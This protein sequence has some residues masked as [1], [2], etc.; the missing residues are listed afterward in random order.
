[1]FVLRSPSLVEF[2]VV[3]VSPE[4]RGVGRFRV[5][6]REGVNRVRLRGRVGRHPL[7]PGTY[8][9]VAR[10]F[11]GGRTV[12]DTRLV[13]VEK[14]SRREL[15][16]ARGAN[17][18]PPGASPGSASAPTASLGTPKTGRPDKEAA[19]SSPEHDSG[20]LGARS[21]RRALSGV[22]HVADLPLWLFA[23]VLL[24]V[25]LLTAGVSL[26]KTPGGRAASLIVGTTGA[27]VLLVASIA[28]AVL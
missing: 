5:R 11:P 20:V 7:V 24:A 3:Q 18:C 14:A 22:T 15:R 27:V 10:T 28:Y 17:A 6:G 8:R 16:R 12:A 23:L 2:V 19:K 21:A 26:A 9:I 4:C 25:V 1:V 13:V